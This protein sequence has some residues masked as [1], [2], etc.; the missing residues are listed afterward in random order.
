[1]TATSDEDTAFMIDMPVASIKAGTIKNPPPI[2]KKPDSIPVASPSPT[3]AGML[4]QS[5]CTSGRPTRDRV[6][7]I[8]TAI[9]SI[10]SA[11]S[12]SSFWPSSILPNVEPI[13]A[14]MIPAAAKVSA[15]DQ[16][17]VPPRA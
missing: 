9:T 2:P 10:N 3:M 13:N 14:P 12:A 16:R 5:I 17:T 6:F 4:D 11:N 1:M 15:Q 8:N 7:S